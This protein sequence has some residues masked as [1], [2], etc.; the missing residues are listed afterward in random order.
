MKSGETAPADGE[1]KK[2]PL[3]TDKETSKPLLPTDS[4]DTLEETLDSKQREDLENNRVQDHMKANVMPEREYMEKELERRKNTPLNIAV[5]GNSGVGKTSF[6]NTIRGLLPTDKEAGA[7]GT[8]QTTLEPKP[9]KDPSSPNLV[10]WDLP[11]V[12]TPQYPR[13]TY[14]EQ[15]S[16]DRYDFFI[17]LSSNRFTTIDAW[18]ATEAQQA[19]KSCFFARTKVDN[20]L[21]CQSEDYPDSY[22]EEN[23]LTELRCYLT[24]NLKTSDQ[25]VNLPDDVF[26]ISCKLKCKS[27]WNEFP[28]LCG[29]LIEDRMIEKSKRDALISAMA[30]T[31]KEVI[32][33]K[34]ELLKKDVTYVAALSAGTGAIPSLYYNF[35]ETQITNY[36]KELRIDETSLER[37]SRQ[38]NIPMTSML[39]EIQAHCDYC[40]PKDIARAAR[41]HRGI[42]HSIKAFIV[43]A[44]ATDRSLRKFTAPVAGAVL[45]ADALISFPHLAS[46]IKELLVKL[47][48]AAINIQD[49]VW[50]KCQEKRELPQSD[51]EVAIKAE[52]RE[53]T[54]GDTG[55]TNGAEVRKLPKDDTTESSKNKARE[56][57]KEDTEGTSKAGGQELAKEDAVTSKA[58]ARE[59][60]HEHRVTRTEKAE[61]ENKAMQKSDFNLLPME[62]TERIVILTKMPNL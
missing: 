50:A 42:I 57:N 19:R 58:E 15:I 36:F 20:D 41:N 5:I 60:P 39:R 43:A 32:I 61:N 7:V 51:T 44:T 45:V 2:I 26:L 33:A 17:I 56:L 22:N 31:G 14:K 6:I 34:Y 3:M 55:V 16:F 25:A 27:K 47:K 38:F 35:L 37:L 9:Y 12:G 59:P 53:L 48:T 28:K 18:L 40:T 8:V 10:Y 54:Q 29:R 21:R 62:E 52:T 46:A 23:T 4:T 11:G 24:D 1:E 49:L 30:V 13:E